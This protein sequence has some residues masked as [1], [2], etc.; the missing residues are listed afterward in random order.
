MGELLMPSVEPLLITLQPWRVLSDSR[1]R[2]G[3][4]SAETLLADRCLGPARKGRHRPPISSRR[5]LC[6]HSQS[7]KV[8]A[9]F[10]PH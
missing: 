5:C 1:G 2:R 8:T 9:E 7:L 4:C 6:G 3:P 10:N